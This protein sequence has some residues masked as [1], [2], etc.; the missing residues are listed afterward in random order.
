MRGA[1]A[2][3]TSRSVTR[4]SRRGR[5]VSHVFIPRPDRLARPDD[6]VDAIELETCLRREI[7]VT[8]VFMNRVGKPLKRGQKLAI[9]N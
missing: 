9:G 6:V 2:A 8:I 7:G 4:L 1:L 5:N 3:S